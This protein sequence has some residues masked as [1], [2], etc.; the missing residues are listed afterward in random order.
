[1]LEANPTKYRSQAV[2]PLDFP[3]PYLGDLVGWYKFIEGEGDTVYNYASPTLTSQKLPDLTVYVNT[4]TFWSI[5][6]GF[7]SAN[8]GSKNYCRWTDAASILTTTTLGCRGSFIWIVG[9]DY[10][11][12][13]PFDHN[14]V[15]TE[16]SD[17][18]MMIAYQ[19]GGNYPI[20]IGWGTGGTIVNLTSSYINRW[21]FVFNAKETATTYKV[22][23][24]LDDGTLLTS[25]LAGGFGASQSIKQVRFFRYYDSSNARYNHFYGSIGDTIQYRAKLLTLS[26]WGSWYDSL[27]SR[28]DMSARSGW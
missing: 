15:V 6:A 10:A 1:M 4:T 22:Y 11:Y 28:Y 14:E 5:K 13:H 21:L 8:S 20:A 27:R 9:A 24:V 18:S 7:G 25:S 16:A 12:P 17:A 26:E 19:V 23:A 3:L 2:S